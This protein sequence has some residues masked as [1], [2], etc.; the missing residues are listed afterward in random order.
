MTATVDGG[1]STSLNSSS[2]L[3]IN[4]WHHVIVAVDVTND[5]L[6]IFLDGA[7]DG[8]T[9]Y[10]GTGTWT[11]AATGSAGGAFSLSDGFS[12][13]YGL[14][15]HLDEWFDTTTP[16]TSSLACYLC[17]CGVAND[18]SCMGVPG[19]SFTATGRNAS[20]CGSCT[21]PTFQSTCSGLGF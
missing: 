12:S 1:T 14:T 9:S 15:G 8:S 20:A 11:Y 19:G 7:Q 13:G 5:T 6:K 2:S 16:V 21:L 3:S 4:T 10:T 18:Q 17:S